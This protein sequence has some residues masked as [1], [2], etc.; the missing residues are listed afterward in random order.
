MRT[1]LIDLTSTDVS[2]ETLTT[3]EAARLVGCTRQHIVDLCD[4]GDLPYTMVGTHRRVRI[5]DVESIRVGSEKMTRDQRRS[6]RLAY[7]VAGKI[8]MDPVG[9]FDV[10]RRNLVPMRSRVRGQ[11]VQWLDEWETLLDGSVDVLLDRLTD[12]SPH[13]RELRQNNPFAGI[14]SDMEREQV[15]AAWAET[16]RGVSG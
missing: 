11:A 9:A 16:E 6:L 7:A 14:L 4:R 8:A 12:R 1:H 3:G 15:L 5:A 2:D 10:A 13:G